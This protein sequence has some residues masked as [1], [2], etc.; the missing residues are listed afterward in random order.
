MAVS[1]SMAGEVCNMLTHPFAMAT[2]NLEI[3]V[4]TC[5]HSPNV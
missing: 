2:A 5:E 1:V 4:E 3:D